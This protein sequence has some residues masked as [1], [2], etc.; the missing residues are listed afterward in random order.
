MARTAARNLKVI[1][2]AVVIALSVAILPAGPGFTIIVLAVA[3]CAYAAVHF[4]RSALRR[5][6]R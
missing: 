3:A 2:W 1:Y 6:K 5:S 4:L